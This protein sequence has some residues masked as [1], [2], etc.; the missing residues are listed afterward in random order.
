MKIYKII[1]GILL[2]GAP[3]TFHVASPY[4]IVNMP[5]GTIS[6]PGGTAYFAIHNFQFYTEQGR[7]DYYSEISN[8]AEYDA[9]FFFD[10]GI[11]LSLEGLMTIIILWGLAFYIISS[12]IDNKI[13][14]IVSDLV[15]IGFAIL[16]LL[17]FLNFS[18][19]I[20][21]LITPTF[22][23]PMFT[24]LAGLLGL[25]GLIHSSMQLKK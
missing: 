23:I 16:S 20:L 24:I 8:N 25:G 12:L 2:F 19:K 10:D 4:Y 18:E 7:T 5:L 17:V 9:H 3:I 1:I 11:K 15:M 21:A 6:T 14:N 22:G 13:L